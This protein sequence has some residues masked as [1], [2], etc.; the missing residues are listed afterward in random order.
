[1][2]FSPKSHWI[3]PFENEGTRAKYYAIF[4][5]HVYTF[6]RIWSSETNQNQNRIKSWSIV[7][8][9]KCLRY[10]GRGE[11]YTQFIFDGYSCTHWKSQLKCVYYANKNNFIC[12]RLWSHETKIIS[13]F[14]ARVLAN[15]A[16]IIGSILIGSVRYFP[17]F[18]SECMIEKYFSHFGHKISNNWQ[19]CLITIR[20]NWGCLYI[21]Y[22][23]VPKITVENQIQFHYS[24]NK[25]LHNDFAKH[26][27]N[28][29]ISISLKRVQM[30]IKNQSNLVVIFL[31][32]FSLSFI[33]PYTVWLYGIDF[34]TYVCVYQ[35][36]YPFFPFPKT[37]Q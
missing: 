28:L 2:L 13:D 20:L 26:K 6:L 19:I 4:I 21:T 35:I 3:F 30:Q 12:L 17:P 10:T 25:S 29:W 37:I 22:I 34:P 16:R 8:N 11:I 15:I 36:F 24:P 27:T 7:P 14:T 32:S 1:M 5:W 18:I 9:V 23:Y 33:G 31:F